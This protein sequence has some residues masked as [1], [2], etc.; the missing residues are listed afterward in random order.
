MCVGRVG[1]RGCVS[2]CQ[3]A[4]AHVLS[5]PFSL[6]L[7]S[8]YA[9]RRPHDFVNFI[10]QEKRQAELRELEEVSEGGGGGKGCV[11]MCAWK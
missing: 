7:P 4:A 6:Q 5:V 10:E 11:C 3:C 8:Q 9:L 1:G 2:V